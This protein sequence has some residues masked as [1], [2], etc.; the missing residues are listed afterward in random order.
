MLRENE[1]FDYEKHNQ[2][3]HEMRLESVRDI[4]NTSGFKGVEALLGRAE[5]TSHQVGDLMTEI[6]AWNDATAEF[7]DPCIRAAAGDNA[8]RFKSCLAGF[9][10]KAES[11]YIA[12]LVDQIE[13]AP[14]PDTLL[15]LLLCLPYGAATW[16]FLED[17]AET[18]RNAYWRQVE[19]GFPGAAAR[20]RVVRGRMQDASTDEAGECAVPISRDGSGRTGRCVE[21]KDQ[22]CTVSM[23][24]REGSHES[25]SRP[26]RRSRFRG[27]TGPTG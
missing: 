16:L 2:R 23:S 19:R 24:R 8:S 26:Q 1:E 20:G 18:F 10:W 4:W 21:G 6:L 7:V 13:H 12:R 25:S 3:L 17:K 9:L 22:T 5:E 14:N 11:G 15:V 27:G